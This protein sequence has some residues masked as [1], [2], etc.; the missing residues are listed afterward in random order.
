MSKN[1]W[2]YVGAISFFASAML[3]ELTDSFIA[4][5]CLFGIM[6]GYCWLVSKVY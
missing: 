2:M 1:E 3:F 6:L 5:G 4:A